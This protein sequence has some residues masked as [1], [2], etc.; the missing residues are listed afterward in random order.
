MASLLY[1]LVNLWRLLRNLLRGA[2]GT[3]DY[4]VLEVSGG[5]PEFEP[6][7]GLLRRLNPR[8]RLQPPTLEALRERLDGISSDGRPRGVVLRVRSLDAGWTALEEL[9]MELYRFRESGGRVVA[10]LTEPDTRSYYLACAADEVLATPVSTVGVVGLGAR[11]NF[12]KD[13]LDRL[14]VEAEV[15]AVSPYKAAGDTFTR[16]DFSEESREQVERILDRRFEEVCGAIA[17]GRDVTPEQARELVDNAPY[18]ASEALE[19]G[20]LDGVLYEDEVPG[21][22]GGE[23]SGAAKLAEWEVARKRLRLPYLRRSRKRVGI[24]TLSGTIV[25][26]RSRRLPVPLP[27]IGGEQAGSES[28]IGALRVAEQSPAVGS[29][30]FHVDT[31]GGDALASDLIWREVER[32]RSEKPVVVLMGE[33]AASGGYYVSAAVDHVVARRNTVTGSIGVIITRPVLAGLYEKLGVN[34]VAL[35]RGARANLLD[36]TQRPSEDEI[37]VLRR[38]LESFYAEFK[39]RVSRGRKIPPDDLEEIAGGRV[40]TGTEA[41]ENGLVD[42]TGGLRTALEK[43]RELGGAKDGAAPVKIQPPKAARPLPGDPVREAVEAA[44]EALGELRVTRLW[45]A[46]PYDI[47]DEG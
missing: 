13:G 25:R 43:A 32:I 28:V 27:L 6:Q 10:H 17:R 29:I 3:P 38:Q 37:R 5:L 19:R 33:T 2:L 31:R 47:S 26:G 1:A 42:E 16:N 40:W 21:R 9:R 14:G 12:L 46:A 39:D 18:P 11:A 44:R 8:N 45:A 35:G 22:L 34:P 20:L 7:Q 36:P 23:R 41:L 24:V 4:V 30:L 15:I